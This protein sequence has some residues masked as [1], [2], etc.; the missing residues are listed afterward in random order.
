VL[1]TRWLLRSRESNSSTIL[2]T[3]LKMLEP[4]TG[5]PLPTGI[6]LFCGFHPAF[7]CRS[8]ELWLIPDSMQEQAALCT[9]SA[10]CTPFASDLS[11]I[12]HDNT[13]ISLPCQNWQIIHILVLMASWQKNT[14]Y[15][16]SWSLKWEDP[17]PRVSSVPGCSLH[18][19][20]QRNASAD[21]LKQS[22]LN[23]LSSACQCGQAIGLAPHS[24]I[25]LST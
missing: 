16:L 4:D 5:P 6:S 7:L 1:Y 2:E 3:S 18:G 15:I 8:R 25:Q 14:K 9:A 23:C 22:L 12:W 17:A 10:L 11:Y 20:G 21:G 19:W 24:P 13:Q